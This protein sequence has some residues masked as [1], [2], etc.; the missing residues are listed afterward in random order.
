MSRE[1]VTQGQPLT[2]AY[3]DRGFG[4]RAIDVL[5][6][7]GDNG[8]AIAM[9]QASKLTIG[10]TAQ[11]GTPVV[12][13]TALG[14]PAADSIDVSLQ[15]KDGAGN[16]ISQKRRVLCWV[17]ATA[18]ATSVGTDTTGLTTAVQTGIAIYVP[19]ANLVFECLTDATGL[20]KVRVTDGAGAQT[21][22]VNFAL[23]DGTI[24]SSAAVTT[25]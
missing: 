1:I 18:G 12:S 6:V 24:L 5:T 17:S 10:N 9:G 25:T 13:Q 8:G 21:R 3:L 11:L 14:V 23:D 15:L 20:L 16:K 4:G 7:D 2:V 19:V 22:F